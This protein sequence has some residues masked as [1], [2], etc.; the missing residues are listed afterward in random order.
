M[1]DEFCKLKDAAD[2]V[3]NTED[4]G[5][6][7]S[8]AT[9][10]EREVDVNLVQIGAIGCDIICP[11]DNTQKIGRAE[12]QKEQQEDKVVGQIY[13]WVE[14]KQKVVPKDSAKR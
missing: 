12:L 11:G 14:K 8:S 13:R 10:K 5:M 1:V 2:K 4:M 6:L 9:R 3:V 7:L